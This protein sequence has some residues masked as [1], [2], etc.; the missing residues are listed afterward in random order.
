MHGENLSF[1]LDLHKRMYHLILVIKKCNLKIVIK[2]FYLQEQFCI[3][4]SINLNLLPLHILFILYLIC[5]NNKLV[6][7]VY[8]T[9]PVCIPM[10]HEDQCINSK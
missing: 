4:N 10:L 2:S 6:A 8:L 3:K 5:K 1:V 7:F 9:F